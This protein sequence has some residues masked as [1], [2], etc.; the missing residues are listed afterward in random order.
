M[1]KNWSDQDPEYAAEKQRHAM[2]LPSRNYL[3]KVLGEHAGPLTAQELAAHLQ[4]KPEDS[5]EGFEKRLQA[6]VRDGQLV[7]NRRGA[8][9]PLP[10]MNVVRGRVQGHR[11]GFGFLIREDAGGP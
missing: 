11:D 9:G 10:R 6:M 5:A 8:Y 4:L 3:L 7:Q 1:K 2:P